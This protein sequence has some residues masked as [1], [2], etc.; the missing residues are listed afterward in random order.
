MT[1]T[2][3]LARRAAD[4]DQVVIDAR[5]AAAYNGWRLSGE[6]RGGHIPGA[7]SL[8]VRWTRY[9]DWIEVVER[10]GLEPERPVTVYGYTMDEARGLAER[11][12][13][14]G[15]REVDVYADFLDEWVAD[16]DRPLARLERHRRLVHPDWLHGLMRGR[17]VEAAPAGEWVV[18]HAH[19]GNP[20]DYARG[21]IPGAV[22]LD[23]NG[24]EASETWNRRSPEELAETLLR[25]GIRHDTTVV[26]YGRYSHPTYEH[27]SPGQSAG[28]LAAM[29]CAAILLFAG[30]EDVRVLNGGIHAWEEAGFGLSTDDVSPEPAGD[31]GVEIPARPEYMV[32]LHEARRMLAA[33]D[34]ELVSVRSWPEFIGQRSGYH[35]ID[36]KGRI[37]GAVFGNCGSDAY[38]MENYRNLDYTTREYGEIAREWTAA[39]IVPEKHIAF[40]C[41]TGWRGSEAFMNAYLMGWPRISVYDGGWLEWSSEPSNPI[42]TGAPS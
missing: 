17:R 25:L 11:L 6:P 1:S 15:F 22:A 20:D 12:E 30:V 28:H 13:R 41:G 9:L 10:K 32:D 4:P 26:L 7:R 34:A 42:E 18:C 14:L 5:P 24:L 19:F 29:R 35:Y 23:T 33:D 27:E 39:G 2:E 31:F 37:P 16:P 40:Y 3:R 38:H 21:H 8:P 36:A